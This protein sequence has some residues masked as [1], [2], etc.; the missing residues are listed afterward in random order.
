MAAVIKL[1][2]CCICA[3][4][5]KIRQAFG[6]SLTKAK[7]YWIECE[8]G[9][10]T[11]MC[12]EYEDAVN[13]WNW[14]NRETQSSINK[15][16]AKTKWLKKVEED[17]DRLQKQ[18]AEKVKKLENQSKLSPLPTSPEKKKRH[19]R[20]KAEMEAARI[21]SSMEETN[22]KTHIDSPEKKKRHRRTKA[23]MEAYRASL[24]NNESQQYLSKSRRNK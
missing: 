10:R 13:F 23:E 19:R 9:L 12:S 7:C 15:N 2:E 24:K 4:G 6:L 20:T 22:N 1:N 3:G 5:G 14:I 11:P 8:C 21:K 17:N 16:N 18:T